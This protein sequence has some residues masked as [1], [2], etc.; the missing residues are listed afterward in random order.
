[1]DEYELEDIW[2]KNLREFNGLIRLDSIIVK[3][4]NEAVQNFSSLN[5]L[6]NTEEFID[7]IKAET[8]EEII[9]DCKDVN[10]E[11]ILD[12]IK[13]QLSIVKYGI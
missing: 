7:K 5:A 11:Y 8:Y 2:K 1:M 9:E 12:R 10:S 13:D 4:M 6:N 3:S